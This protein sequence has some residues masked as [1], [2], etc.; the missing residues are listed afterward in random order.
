MYSKWNQVLDQA[1][2]GAALI[3]SSC[4]AMAVVGNFRSLKGA[5]QLYP[6]A[7]RFAPHSLFG[8]TKIRAYGSLTFNDNAG[9]SGKLTVDRKQNIKIEITEKS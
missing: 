3:Y 4:Q 5:C 1:V 9:N 2:T 6:C 7:Q 8:N